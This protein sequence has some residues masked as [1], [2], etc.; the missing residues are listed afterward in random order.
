VIYYSLKEKPKGEVSIEIV[1]TAGASI[2]KYSSEK[3]K[4][5]DEP[6]DPDSE[7]PKKQIEPAAGLN[8][9]VWNLRYA[10]LPRVPGYYLYEYQ[11]GANGPMALPGSYQVRVTA[12]GKSQT[13]PFELKL[14][15]RVHVS[16]EDLEKQFAL[17]M[18]IR[19]ELTRLY[20]AVNQIRDV[21]SQIRGLHDRLPVKESSKRIQAAGDELSGK[22]SHVLDGII[23]LK[24]SAN[25]DSLAFP[26]GLDGKFAVLAANVSEGTDS[27]PT[28]ASYRVFEKLKSQLDQ[29][30]TAWAG[31]RAADLA[32]FQKL[33]AAENI[34][35]I[36]VRDGATIEPAAGGAG[37]VSQP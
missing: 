21:Q 32:A 15:P 27:A 37:K 24:I 9:F 20:D 28:E 26:I 11:A 7:K 2:R 33:T 18:Q 31:L 3:I 12:E 36:F 5:P 17:S 22:L 4:E 6:L 14:D 16:R 34:Q 25:E 30:L 13:A 29:Q 10:E 23:D 35:A 8:R 1:D 19:G